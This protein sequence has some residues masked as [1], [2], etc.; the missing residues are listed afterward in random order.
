MPYSTVV[1]GRC[2]WLTTTT[3]SSS[4]PTTKLRNRIRDY[5]NAL[6]FNALLKTI[7][8]KYTLICEI[9]N[10]DCFRDRKQDKQNRLY[11]HQ[12]KHVA[13]EKS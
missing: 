2:I 8:K 11:L 9:S 10:S 3:T 7:Y 4:S 1:T 12:E 5:R 6:F 13:K